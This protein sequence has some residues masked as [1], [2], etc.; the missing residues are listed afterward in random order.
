[1]PSL[2]VRKSYYGWFWTMSSRDWILCVVFACQ[3]HALSV[4]PRVDMSAV[5]L[6]V[7]VCVCVLVCGMRQMKVG[8]MKHR[9]W[10]TQQW[11]GCEGKWRSSAESCCRLSPN[12]AARISCPPSLSPPC[13]LLCFFSPWFPVVFFFVFFKLCDIWTLLLQ[14]WSLVL[15]TW[16]LGEIVLCRVLTC[17]LC[18]SLSL[19]QV[20]W[21]AIVKMLTVEAFRRL[22]DFWFC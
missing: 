4:S 22:L 12:I 10:K 20:A 18:S 16:L 11:Q 15:G 3:S 19:C 5:A 6:S 2:V 13:H 8:I 17:V 9:R 14:Q 7:C 1:M 21:E